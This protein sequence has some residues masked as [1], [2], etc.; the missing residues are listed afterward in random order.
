MRVERGTGC[1]LLVVENCWA[2]GPLARLVKNGIYSSATPRRYPLIGPNGG[3]AKEVKTNTM[4]F[5][6]V[7][8]GGRPPWMV[9]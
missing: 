1:V 2:M 6:W 5:F 9:Q 8:F 3:D 7:P 4:A